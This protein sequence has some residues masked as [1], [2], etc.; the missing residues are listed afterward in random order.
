MPPSLMIVFVPDSEP[1]DG[2]VVVELEPSS[3]IVVPGNV[4]GAVVDEEPSGVVV[5]LEDGV[6]P[7]TVVVANVDKDPR[8][9]VDVLANVVI[10][11]AS[12]IGATGV[13]LTW[14]D[15]VETTAQAVPV[16]RSVTTS[17]ASTYLETCMF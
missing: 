7:M 12:M 2:A 17:Q 8:L 1:V 9:V 3:G 5:G 6:D 10:A 11:P 14:S 4:A 15:A 16:T 13:S